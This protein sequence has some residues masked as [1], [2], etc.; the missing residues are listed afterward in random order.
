MAAMQKSH[1]TMAVTVKQYTAKL[2]TLNDFEQIEVVEQ[3]G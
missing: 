2:Q 3:L 1:A